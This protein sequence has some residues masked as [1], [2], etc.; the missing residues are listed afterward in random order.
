LQIGLEELSYAFSD[1]G[2]VIDPV[3]EAPIEEV[4]IGDA[5][6]EKLPADDLSKQVEDITA[7]IKF[8]V[9][10]HDLN[11][12]IELTQELRKVIL[13][14]KKGGTTTI[15]GWCYDARGCQGTLLYPAPVEKSTCSAA[16]GKSWDGPGGCVK[17]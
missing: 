14:A 4:P 12:A 8:S 11:S 17:I 9:Q 16:G 5:P 15:R 3:S 10:D 6:I 7:A 1:I 13:I 2:I